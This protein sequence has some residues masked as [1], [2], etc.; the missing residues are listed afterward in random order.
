MSL[1]AEGVGL[2]GPRA[3][4]RECTMPTV[5]PLARPAQDDLAGC[6]AALEAF[7]PSDPT[8]TLNLGCLLFKEGRYSEAVEQFGEAAQVG[9]MAGRDG[10][11]AAAE[12]KF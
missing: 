2:A 5:L 8:A 1:R 9:A 11:V 6:R 10:R 3:M 4:R 12:W 7:P